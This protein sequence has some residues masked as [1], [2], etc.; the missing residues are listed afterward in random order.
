MMTI[1]GSELNMLHQLLKNTTRNLLFFRETQKIKI[2]AQDGIIGYLDDIYFKTDTWS[3]QYVEIKDERD[4]TNRRIIIAPYSLYK[5][6]LENKE[7]K[8][9]LTKIEIYNSP[10]I[11]KNTMITHRQEILLAEHYGWPKYWEVNK[12]KSNIKKITADISLQSL[13]QLIPFIVQTRNGEKYS[14][15]DFLINFED[16]KIPFVILNLNNN[17]KKTSDI[18]LQ[19][20]TSIDLQNKNI[21]IKLANIRK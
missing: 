3:I 13:K 5:P 6:N 14:I 21:F 17:Q 7:C 10:Q 20:V 1:V 15:K 2:K 12:S 9:D 18:S 11:N 19:L 16:W 8:T 4:H